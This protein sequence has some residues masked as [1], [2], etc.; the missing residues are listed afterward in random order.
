MYPLPKHF[1][2]DNDAVG[3]GFLTFS[4]DP[5][6]GNGPFKYVQ[7]RPG[8]FVELEAFDD[9]LFGKPKIDRLILRKF[10]NVESMISAFKAK[11][12]DLIVG[13]PIAFAG[14]LEAIENVE[15]VIKGASSLQDI[16][17]NMNENTEANLF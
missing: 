4:N 12:V 17:I 1:W 15:V 7:W 3:E 10:D 16:Y 5:F 2:E 8:E 13:V 14:D 6:I 9:F 11:E